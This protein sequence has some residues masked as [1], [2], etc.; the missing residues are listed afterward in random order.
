M[1]EAASQN[2]QV[3]KSLL[4]VISNMISYRYMSKTEK[5]IAKLKS[6]NID[7]IELRSLLKKLNWSLDH[8]TGSHEVWF[9]DGA[10]FVLATHGKDL[11]L[12]QIKQA[13]KALL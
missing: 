9:K 10:R 2:L 4:T 8:S 12:Y 6:G 7:A 5:L 3:K 13:Q 1:L 11:K